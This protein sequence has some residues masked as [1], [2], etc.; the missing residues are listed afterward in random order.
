MADDLKFSKHY[1]LRMPTDMRRVNIH[2]LNWN[3]EFLD[4]MCYSL[5]LGVDSKVDSLG[6]KLK[7]KVNP[8]GTYDD[9]MAQVH[10][11]EINVLDYIA[12]LSDVKDAIMP[13][14]Y[15]EVESYEQLESDDLYK[16]KYVIYY[17]IDDENNCTEYLWNGLKFINLEYE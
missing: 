13:Y 16:Q 15:N 14:T 11:A 5:K 9:P 10:N 12:T 4:K 17:V 3:S 6:S 7:R 1:N 2:D 8:D